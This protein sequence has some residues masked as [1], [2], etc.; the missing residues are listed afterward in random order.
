MHDVQ[1]ARAFGRNSFIGRR[2]GILFFGVEHWTFELTS[3]GGA[4]GRHVGRKG[5]AIG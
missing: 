3:G 2:R 1:A 4:A 5:E